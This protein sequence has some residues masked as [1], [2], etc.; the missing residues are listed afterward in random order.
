[1]GLTVNK[2]VS[3]IRNIATSGSNP[4]EFRI[5]DSQILFWVNEIRAMLIA[6]SYQKNGD[7]L[8]I[9]QQ[10]IHC[11]ELEQVDESECCDIL[12]GCKVLRTVEE[13]PNT[14]ET[15]GDMGIIRIE[16]PTGDIIPYTNQF[17]NKY[18]QYNKYTGNK[19]KWLY[20]NGHIYILNETFLT[21]INMIGVFDDPTELINF[22]GCDG[23]TCFDWNDDYP[24]SLKMANDITNIVLKTKVYPYLQLP[25]DNTNDANNTTI[26]TNTKNL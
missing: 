11:L 24:C 14:V 21:H 9:W 5:E 25:Q 20:K 22:V 12:T 17:S 8:D 7:M 16:T 15:I 19:R 23:D 13:I 1:M 18:D 3:D 10:P 6:Q 26:P 4:I 2:I